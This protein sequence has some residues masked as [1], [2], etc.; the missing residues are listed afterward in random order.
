[1]INI[2]KINPK[3]FEKNEIIYNNNV[4]LA[5]EKH[6]LICKNLKKIHSHLLD[7]ENY[8]IGILIDIIKK[9]KDPKSL[10]LIREY[11]NIHYNGWTN[12]IRKIYLVLFSN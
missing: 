2:D 11:N 9:Y 8:E 3:Y 1:M 4:D 12:E 6:K 7:L 5:I 10:E